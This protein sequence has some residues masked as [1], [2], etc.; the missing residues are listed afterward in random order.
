[1]QKKLK[2]KAHVMLALGASTDMLSLVWG[3]VH[4]DIN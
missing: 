1:M 3:D 4:C 2:D